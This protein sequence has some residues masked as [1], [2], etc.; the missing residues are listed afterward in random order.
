MAKS[1][2]LRMASGVGL[3]TLAFFLVSLDPFLGAGPMA[4]AGYS[5]KTP[6]VSVERSLKGDRL[7]ISHPLAVNST[8][9]PDGLRSQPSSAQRAQLP[10]GC[11]PAF[12]AIFSSKFGN[13][14][15]RCTT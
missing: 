14:Y 12:S 3:L 9:S 11:D 7:P 1:L 8:T 2:C 15:R 13:V 10:I 5:G 4:G 6:A